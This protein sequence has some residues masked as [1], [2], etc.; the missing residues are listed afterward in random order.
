MHTT[1]SNGGTVFIHNG[2]YSGG[3][4]IKHEGKE[5]E[6]PFDDITEFVALYVQNEKITKLENSSVNEILG[7]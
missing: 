1:Y 2:D 7:I 6:I 3:V 5:I 4:I